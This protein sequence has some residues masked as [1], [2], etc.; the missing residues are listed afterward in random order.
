MKIALIE[1]NRAEAEWLKE[2]VEIKISQLFHISAFDLFSSIEEYLDSNKN[3]EL[4]FIDCVLTDGNGTD[5]AKT[6]REKNSGASIVFTTS[7]LDYATKGYE[8]NALRY[9][10]KPI[11]EE[12]LEEAIKAFAQQKK[13]FPVVELTGTAR[14]SDFVPQTEILYIEYVDRKVLCRLEDRFVETTKTIREFEDELSS[15][16]FFRTSR[17]FL[18]NF[19]HIAK[20]T[21]NTLIMRNGEHVTISRRN[22]FSFNQA[23]I[24]FLKRG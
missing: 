11:S 4:Y 7:Y 12:A 2:Q 22:L 5:L 24:Q 19:F 20:K 6:I 17:S 15:E 14:Y 23:Y 13:K 18:V 8:S 3:Y 21:D 9:L 10:L 16:L 1:D